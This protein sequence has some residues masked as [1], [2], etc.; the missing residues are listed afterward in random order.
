M[1][2]EREKAGNTGGG[3]ETISRGAA[4]QE[5]CLTEGGTEYQK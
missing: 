1:T 5:S 2:T 4:A 3:V